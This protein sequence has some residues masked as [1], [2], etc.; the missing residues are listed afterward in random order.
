MPGLVRVSAPA[1]DGHHLMEPTQIEMGAT[2]NMK[3]LGAAFVLALLA[4]PLVGVGVATAADS[5]GQ[6]GSNSATVGIRTATQEAGDDRGSYEFEIFPSGVLRDFVAVA[7]YRD[8]PIHIRLLA[9]DASTVT[10]SSYAVQSSAENPNDVG[11]WITLKKDVLRLPPHTEKIV[12]FEIGVPVG[13]QPGDHSGAILVSL[14]T[15]DP[16]PEGGTVIVDH[17]VGMKVA[18][19][20]PGDLSPELSVSDLKVQWKGGLALS[21]AGG[22]VVS[23]TVHNTGNVIMRATQDVEFSR[24]LGLPTTAAALPAIEQILPGG[25]MEITEVVPGLFG[26]G[27][28]KATVTLHPEAV[29]QALAGQAKN[30]TETVSFKAWPWVLL[31]WLVAALSL[32]GLGGW[33]IR[34][35]RLQRKNAAHAGGPRPSGS[36]AKKVR[37]LTR[38]V[39]VSVAG[40]TV[41]VSGGFGSAAQASDVP[42]WKASTSLK[43]GTAGQP[44]DVVTSGGCPKKATNIVGFGFGQGFP[45]E[46]AVVIANGDAGV[47]QDSSFV[48]PLA[49]NLNGLMALQP[50]PKPFKGTYRFVVSCVE[51]MDPYHSYGDYV[52]AIAFDNPGHWKVKPALSS[53]SG[54]VSTEEPDGAADEADPGPGKDKNKGKKSAK[55][56]TKKD[57]DEAKDNEGASDESDQ[58]ASAE[59]AAAA[60][61]VVSAESVS[62]SSGED[63]MPWWLPV[64]IGTA[65]LLGI[66]LALRRSGLAVLK[67]KQ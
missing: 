37:A 52:V 62:A 66:P 24:A 56:D 60:T 43:E 22:A 35:R 12:P 36:H 44:F 4:I 64:G 47:T 61:G 28:M 53:T 34:R 16:K 41:L 31:A 48:A 11:A 32:I 1:P 17:R 3:R 19:R 38:I 6:T 67:R 18:L 26:A 65:V 15:E 13:A 30:V 58:E 49:D 46:G 20:V 27:P 51:A 7:N 55:A 59:R 23:Y 50:N 9:R 40:L 29:D 39:A 21:G 14:L 45:K 57:S 63:G 33:F 10:G 25:S 2:E 5:D 8:E 42:Q 54:P